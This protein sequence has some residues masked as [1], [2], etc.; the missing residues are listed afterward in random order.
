L[1][2]ELN[3]ERDEIMYRNIE[4]RQIP[5][6]EIQRNL[7]LPEAVKDISLLIRAENQPR[8]MLD[9]QSKD[10]KNK[11]W[12]QMAQEFSSYGNKIEELRERREVVERAEKKYLPP[13][14]GYS[15]RYS[16]Y[17]GPFLHIKNADAR[18][19]L[20]FI[21]TSRLIPEQGEFEYYQ[22]KYTEQAGIMVEEMGFDSESAKQIT[23][24]EV[25]GSVL[26]G[27][28]KIAYQPKQK[29]SE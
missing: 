29:R 27:E 18:K 19:F 9:T 20:G 5:A 16:A 22:D 6:K 15:S 10:K 25:V 7:M 14:T 24:E 8:A 2:E 28:L 12:T 26:R 1:W 23:L 13:R 11:T 17:R 3:Y 21:V 4:S